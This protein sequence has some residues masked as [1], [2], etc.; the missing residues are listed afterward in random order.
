MKRLTALLLLSIVPLL[1]SCAASTGG[2]RDDALAAGRGSAASPTAA[3]APAAIAT[4]AVNAAP[5]AQPGTPAAT[6]SPPVEALPALLP[7]ETHPGQFAFARALAAKLGPGRADRSEAAINQI[8]DGAR[9]QQSIIDAITRPA[10]GKP[11]RDYR[12]IFIND[13]RIRGGV[14]FLRANRAQLESAAK[15]YGVPVEIIVAIIGVETSY[16]K[17]TGSYRVLDAL[18]TLAFHY[19]KRA[20][21]FRG[22]LEQ[23]LSL[24]A[25]SFPQ[26]IDQLKG[27]YAGAMGWGQ[28]MPTSFAEWGVD[29][30]QDESIDLW[31]SKPD[32][33]ASIANYFIEHGWV[34]GE[35]VVHRASARNDATTVTREGLEPT[36][37]VGQLR[38]LGYSAS[39]PLADSTPSN[40]VELDGAQGKEYWITHQNFYVISRYNRSPMY[41]LAVYQLAQ[42]IKAGAEGA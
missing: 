37:T 6:V 25:R 40:L 26:P 9:Y 11:W 1:S 38:G 41:S 35:S 30:D 3:T 42:E 12:P 31:S 36:M 7:G 32:I 19:P 22:E 20:P 2:M 16:G 13:A 27:S 4:P 29:A 14:E 18:A 17:N 10:E 24:P 21:F 15:R 34:S 8:L 23:L 39:E 28:F 33:F 5:R